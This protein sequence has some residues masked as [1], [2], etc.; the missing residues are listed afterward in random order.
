MQIDPRYTIIVLSIILFCGCKPTARDYRVSARQKYEYGDY[1]G[2]IT[3][4]SEVLRLNPDD[5]EAYIFRGIA[6][7]HQGDLAGGIA[8]C[9]AAIRLNP[10]QRDGYMSRGGIRH[11]K[12]TRAEQLPTSHRPFYLNPTLHML[13]S[14]ELCL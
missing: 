7:A 5:L 9:T 10:N 4:Y 13:I 12:A 2:A 6:R 1:A 3:D 11:K 8:D 14:T